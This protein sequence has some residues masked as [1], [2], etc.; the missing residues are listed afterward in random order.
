MIRLVVFDMDGTLVQTERLKAQSYAQA[1]LDLNPS[2]DRF[3]VETAYGTLVGHTREEIATTLMEQF[4][5]E[6][7]SR[8]R[9]EAMAVSEPWEAY[10]G[11][12]LRHYGAMLDD[13]ALLRAHAWPHA[14]ALLRQSRSYFCE[15]A[16]A[17]TSLRD[18]TDRVLHALH[19]ADAF[20]LIRTGDDVTTMKPD[21]EIYRGVTEAFRLE[22]AQGL[23]IEDSPSGI[24]AAVS[25]GLSCI[26]VPTAY[27]RKA[28]RGLV[29][30]G[31][32]RASNVVEE[33][34]ALPTV[35][36]RVLDEAR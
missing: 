6:E 28:V 18:A 31:V 9:M 30:D 17:T 25:A 3:A 7:A 29:Q 16:L 36:R 10:V 13:P 12:R 26:A 33:A 21:P 11:I 32:L 27:T 1:A 15:V 24:R 22:P 20:D 4:G 8:A 2:L 19:V 34:S 23:A 5:L 14:M 35:V